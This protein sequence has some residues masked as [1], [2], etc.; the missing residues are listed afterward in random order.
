[1]LR[2]LYYKLPPALRFAVRWLYYLPAD[3]TDPPPPMVP[4][5]RLIY[6]GRGDFLK[7][8]EAWLEFFKDQG[9]Q[10]HYDFLDIGSGIGRIARALTSYLTGTY[11]GFDAVKTGVTWCQRHISRMHP[12]F[13]F[14][15]VPL[16]NDLYR[17]SGLSAADYRFPYADETFDFACAISVFTHLLPE[18][19]ENYLKET[20]RVLKP[21]GKL[22]ATF[23]LI[24]GALSERTGAFSFPHRRGHYALMDASVQHANVAYDHAY[25]LSFSE[26]VGLK[27]STHI[28]G[29]WRDGVV[30]HTVAFQDVLVWEKRG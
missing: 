1:M 12:N 11:Q 7:Q 20:A 30:G 16:Y 17:A 8:G 19:T 26:S 25:L 29:S 28:H 13:H 22:V 21:K 18:E 2:K 3:L 15:H 6:T 5:R 14:T 10:P 27:L 9:L 24:N 23:F 4:P